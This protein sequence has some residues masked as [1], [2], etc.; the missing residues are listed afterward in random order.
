MYIMCEK[1]NQDA[2][3]RALEAKPSAVSGSREIQYAG[4]SNDQM[5]VNYLRLKAQP[6]LHL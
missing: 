2:I 4:V 1:T 6:K 5:E 3:I